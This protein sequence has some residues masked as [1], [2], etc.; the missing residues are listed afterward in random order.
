MR[1]EFKDYNHVLEEIFVDEYGEPS[2]K[3]CVDI[4]SI[5]K[6]FSEKGI[7]FT[8]PVQGNVG[9]ML[10][11]FGEISYQLRK[12]TKMPEKDLKE[13]ERE[14][15]A[16]AAF[17]AKE[18]EMKKDPKKQKQR[19]RQKE[20][21]GEEEKEEEK[22]KA[23]PHPVTVDLY[24]TS[25]YDLL[26]SIDKMQDYDFTL[27]DLNMVSG[28]ID[29]ELLKEGKIEEQIEEEQVS[30]Q[31]VEPEEED[32]E[33]DRSD[34]SIARSQDRHR[35]E[36]EAR[37]LA[38]IEANKPVNQ[39]SE[40]DEYEQIVANIE[41]LDAIPD[42]PEKAKNAFAVTL[43][44]VETAFDSR[45]RDF[46][47]YAFDL[48]PDRD[49]LIITQPHTVAETSLLQR[50][51]QAVGKANNTFQHVLYLM[52]RDALLDVDMFIRRARQP[53]IE[54]IKQFLTCGLE[55]KE[56]VDEAFYSA[57][58]DPACKN[59]AFIAKIEETVIGAFVL[60]KDVNLQY[61]KSHFHIQDNILLSEHE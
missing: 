57:V 40:D 6:K 22:K 3:K 21:K 13:I 18:E 24:E 31:P 8:G 23:P 7:S 61:Y 37:R 28:C 5:E 50:F 2:F 9:K 14:K 30:E 11:C 44:C 20:K 52:H 59:Q 47:N 32:E 46:L 54:N 42:P 49:Y 35:E 53:D 4:M 55:D 43:F 34:S 19:Q 48:F 10:R 12:L 41:E 17:A 60:S 39:Y 56:E 15:A 16:A 51:T 29:E 33:D 26:Q 1:L 27:L 38:E 45:A 25:I 36:E 58:V